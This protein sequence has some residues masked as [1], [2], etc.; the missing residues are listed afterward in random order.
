MN[1]KDHDLMSQA[2]D[3][4]L[5]F[6]GHKITEDVAYATMNDILDKLRDAQA[7]AGTDAEKREIAVTIDQVE[8]LIETVT[9]G[10]NVR[11]CYSDD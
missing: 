1:T 10:V 11:R 9:H 5:A 2:I 7:A 8:N 3:A 4:M 6:A